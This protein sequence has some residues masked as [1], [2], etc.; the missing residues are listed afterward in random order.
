MF[1]LNSVSLGKEEKNYEV[2]LEFGLYNVMG[3]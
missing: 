3:L 1:A 2:G